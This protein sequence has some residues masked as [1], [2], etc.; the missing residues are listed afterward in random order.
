MKKFFL[1]MAFPLVIFAHRVDVYAE[2]NNGTLE[3]FGYFPDGTPA[4]GVD[5]K[6]FTPDGKLIY[7]GKTDQEGWLKIPL[8]QKVDKVKVV[9]YA[10]LGH[11]AQTTVVINSSPTNGGKTENSQNEPPKEN[12]QPKPSFGWK[13]IFCGLGWIFGIFGILNFV[14]GFKKRKG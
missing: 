12:F 3:I 9:L 11:K 7:E 5:V 2:F 1:L 6:V 14:H 10:G 4:K 8:T 13:E